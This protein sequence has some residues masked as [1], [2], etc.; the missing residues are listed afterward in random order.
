MAP[1]RVVVS[2]DHPVVRSGIRFALE[3]AP[4]IEV[5]GEASDGIQALR[6]VE[7]LTPDVLLLDIEMPYL[8]GIEVTRQLR[9]AGSRVRVLGM[10]AYDDEHYVLEMLALGAAGYLTKDEAYGTLVDA[11]R[12][13]AH[14]QSGW[15]S[16][17]IAARMAAGTRRKG[18]ACSG[19]TE[20]ELEVVRLLAGGKTNQGIADMLYI[21]EKTVEKH[22]G[23][24]FEKFGVSSRVEAAVRAV[25]EGLV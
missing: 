4:D 13:V 11:V 10:S 12:G 25:R 23:S 20:R 7:A 1:I 24:V 14:R 6:L 22:L 19:L 2:D 15:L 18:P 17:R 9:T 8:T 3:K 5:V 21:S 16:R